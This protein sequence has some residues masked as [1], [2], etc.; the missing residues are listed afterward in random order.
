VP[1]NSV[2][3]VCVTS[4]LCVVLIACHPTHCVACV[5]GPKNIRFTNMKFTCQPVYKF[6]C[7]PKLGVTGLRH[8]S[9]LCCTRG[10]PPTHC[11]AVVGGTKNILFITMKF[12][13]QPVLKC[14]CA[15][16]LSFT[17]LCYISVLCCTHG[18][19]PTH[20][21]AGVG[22]PQYTL[23]TNMKFTRQPVLNFGVPLNSVLQ[24]CVTSQFC[25]ALLACPPTYCVAGVGG[26]KTSVSQ[27]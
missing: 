3:Q 20:S 22:G 25:G 6:W 8:I 7:A 10:L 24:L 9:V 27:T 12:A 13:R 1:L 23:F 5:G 17:G 14:W 19:P 16:N 11:V 2:L 18:L 4:Q 21:V 15:P 26:P